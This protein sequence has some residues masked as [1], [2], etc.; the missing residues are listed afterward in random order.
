M[1]ATYPRA[2]TPRRPAWAALAA[3][4]AL[5]GCK[6]KDGGGG[7]G[8]FGRDDPPARS[9]DPLVYGPN[10]I[11]PQNVPVP[12]RGVG[13]KGKADPLTSPTAKPN[14]KTGVGYS[15]DPERFKGTYVPGLGSTP[16]A[17]ASK[18]NDGNELKIDAPDNR[19]PL[20]PAG[21]V[22]PAGNLEAG[23][24]GTDALYAELEKY[25]V[26]R[27]DR[28]LR[29]EDG[30]FVFRAAIPWKDAKRWYE[31]VGATSDE[32]VRQVLDQVVADRK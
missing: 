6:S 18:L 2:R 20:R 7:L 28:A 23:G 32:A 9:R 4:L 14:D 30:K 29:Q 17:L 12:D 3:L 15:N 19:V 1:T 31:G 8:V 24:D 16:A 25:G 10:R 27:A 22:R 5:A 21:D 26:R 13:A 11:P